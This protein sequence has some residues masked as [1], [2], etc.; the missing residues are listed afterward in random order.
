MLKSSYCFLAMVSSIGFAAAQPISCTTAASNTLV[1]AEGLTERIGDIVYSCT[2]T[3]GLAQTVNLSVQL[4]AGIT[5]RISSGTVVTGTVLTVDNGSGPQAVI[6]QPTLLT[7]ATLFWRE[8]PLTFSAP[9]GTLTIRI[10]GLRTNA[11]AMRVVTA[12]LGGSISIFPSTLAVAEP[13]LSLYVG[14]T[15]YLVCAQ[16]GSPVPADTSS[17]K[18]L[19]HDGT[20]FASTRITEGFASAFAPKSAPA[21]LN[22][23]TGTRFLIQYSGYPAGSQLFVPNVVAGS[24]AVQPTAGGD[25]GVPASGGAYAPSSNG[26][27]LLALVVGADSTG[28][29]GTTGYAPGALGSGTVKFDATTELQLVNGAAYAVYEVVDSNPFTLE[30]AQ[31]PTFF[32]LTANT[33]QNTV[34]TAE[35]VTYAPVSTVATASATSPIPRFLEET[36]PND[37]GVLG[38]CAADYFPQLTVG[39]SSIQYTSAGQILLVRRST[40]R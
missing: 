12:S 6:V 30:T 40:L 24:D 35:S 17:F 31:F 33:V 1:P 21:S 16:C 19:L 11:T 9:Q 2:G 39:V 3:P 23:D 10:A 14:N 34:T 5:N 37:F 27:L 13:E 7:P 38:D 25:L 28:A 22:A 15:D 36:P 20:A 29:E 18:S 8:V 32:G 26:S 4:S